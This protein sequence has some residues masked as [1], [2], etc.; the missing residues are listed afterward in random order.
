MKRKHYFAALLQNSLYQIPT[1]RRLSAGVLLVLFTLGITPKVLIHAVVAHH[2]DTHLSVDRDGTDHVNKTSF[3]CSI[4]SLVV[5][6][7]YLLYPISIQLDVPQLFQVRQVE[8]DHQFYSFGHFIF[9][10][11]GPPAVV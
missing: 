5:E 7:P 2:Q 6:V 1:I 3:H 11:R 9:G 4:D 10:L 8:A